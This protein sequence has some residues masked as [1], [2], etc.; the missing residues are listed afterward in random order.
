[1]RHQRAQPVHARVELE[2]HMVRRV[3]LVHG[4]PV[5][6]LV[7][8]HR[9]PQPQARAQLQVARL[10]HALQQQDGAAPAQGAH[11]LGL[12]QVEQREAV[13][14]AQALVHALDAVAVGVGLD[15]G[16]QARAGRGGA[17][18]P[19][20]VAQ[21]VGVDGGLDRTGH[22]KVGTEGNLAILA[23]RGHAHRRRGACYNRAPIQELTFLV[24]FSHRPASPASC[25]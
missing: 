5:D 16:P 11:T 9:V 21:G 13:G 14:A 10:E 20:V 4:Q 24:R 2:E 7:A 22:G 6:L 19:Q 8:V 15:D 25:P 12:G 17:Q 23:P 18:A 3:R 1:M